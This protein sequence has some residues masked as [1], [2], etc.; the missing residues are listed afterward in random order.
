[1]SAKMTKIKKRI[2]RPPTGMKPMVG[3]RADSAFTKRIDAW[4]KKQKDKPTRGE[5]IRQLISYALDRKE[6]EEC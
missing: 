5:A 1:M 4:A 2:G 3:F 6:A